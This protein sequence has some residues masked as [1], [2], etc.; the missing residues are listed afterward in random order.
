M[1]NPINNFYSGVTA[2]T[3]SFAKGDFMIGINGSY[4]TFPP[5]QQTQYYVGKTPPT[6]GYTIYQKRGATGSLNSFAPIGGSN[7]RTAQNKNDL[8]TM[9]SYTGYPGD[10]GTAGL[11]W[12]V[13]KSHVLVTNIDYPRI[14]MNSLRIAL[15]AGYIPSYPES[16]ATMHNLKQWPNAQSWTASFFA[17]STTSLSFTR[18]TANTG[19]L[20]YP[21]SGSYIKT[22]QA[23][24]LDSFLADKITIYGFIKPGAGT[25]SAGT[26]IFASS[27]TLAVGSIGLVFDNTGTGLRYQWAGTGQ[28]NA[29]GITL[30]SSKWQMVA[31]TV[32]TTAQNAKVYNFLDGATYSISIFPSETLSTTWY[33]GLIIGAN[34]VQ[35][36]FFRGEWGNVFV[37]AFVALS[38]AELRSNYDA[39]SSRYPN[40]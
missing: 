18:N 2:D 19:V 10:G 16:G 8:G 36:T 9:I 29:T 25:Q 17:G 13:D 4:T 35:N 31:L 1:P 27:G 6:D 33:Q 40:P 14:N 30:S 5:T 12:Q 28:N 32:D 39:L 37:H 20:N 23:I 11:L 3:G 24:S 21:G 38:A 26:G 15:D 7:I 34:S 22:D